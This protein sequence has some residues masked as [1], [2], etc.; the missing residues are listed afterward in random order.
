MF[1]DKYILRKSNTN[2]F[3]VLSH[4]R[5]RFFIKTGLLLVVLIAIILAI[6]LGSTKIKKPL[7]LDIFELQLKENK[8]SSYVKNAKLLGTDKNKRPFLITAD[9]AI[10]DSSN[11]NLINLV[12]PKADLTLDNKSWVMVSG[13]SGTIYSK[14]NLLEIYGGIDVYSSNGT[15]IHSEEATYNFSE[16]ILEGEKNIKIHGGWGTLNGT[17]FMYN[18]NSSILSIY[19]NPLLT[20]YYKKNDE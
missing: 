12:L 11:K 19:G 6:T 20:L 3:D 2:E 1:A 17:R 10:R 5:I 18:T 9:K 13:K 15:E 4:L 16:G 14:I 8:N 7:L